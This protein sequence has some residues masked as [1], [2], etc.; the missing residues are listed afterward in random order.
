MRYKGQNLK[1][2]RTHISQA[3]SNTTP[4]W[5]QGITLWQS[6]PL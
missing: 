6:E 3:L 2:S 1:P 4:N 5:A